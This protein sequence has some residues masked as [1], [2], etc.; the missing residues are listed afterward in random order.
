MRKSILTL[1]LVLALLVSIIGCV[2][3]SGSSETTGAPRPSSTEAPTSGQTT[4]TVQ[5]TAPLTQPTTVPTES[6]T[7]PTETTEETSAPTEPE[8]TAPT[9]TTVVPTE[10]ATTVPAPTEPAPTE[11]VPTEPP[12]PPAIPHKVTVEASGTLTKQNDKAVIDYSN[13]K[14][15][16]VMVRY[17]Q[18]SDKRLKVLVKG[19]T[20][21]YQYNLPGEQWVAF[22]LSDGNGKYQISVCINASGSKYAVELSLTIDP[23]AMTDEFAPFLHSNQYVDFDAAPNTAA[24]AAAL[25]A[26]ITD[27]LKKVEKVYDFVVQGLTYDKELAANVKTGYLP[28]LDEVLAKRK[29]ICFDY[30]ALMTGM[31]RSQGVPTK[32]VVGYAGEVYHAWISVWS[33][34]TGW[35]D[36][37]IYFDGTSWQ[38]MDPTFASSG[39]SSSDILSFI[40]NGAN[41]SAK[42]FY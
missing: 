26:G 33:E 10:P 22:P 19:P 6:T 16:Y 18:A 36:G 7:A 23:V 12:A 30:A 4:A 14:D 34:S 28:V 13:T 37:V 24:K 39:G 29:G 20:T 2:K 5:S 1:A 17:N 21:T 9:E 41:Y 35:V 11:P 27:P 8:T 15:G 31:L 3:T 40:G 25:T 32:L 42:Y 38:R